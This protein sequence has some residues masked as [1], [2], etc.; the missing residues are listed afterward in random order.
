[1]DATAAASRIATAIKDARLRAGLTQSELGEF[2]SADRFA[3]AALESATV[4]TQ[5]R[6]LLDVLDAVGLEFDLRPHTQRLAAAPA[7]AGPAEPSAPVA[8]QPE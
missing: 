3:I 4:T 6:R 2:V 8:S 1:M 7:P 5:V